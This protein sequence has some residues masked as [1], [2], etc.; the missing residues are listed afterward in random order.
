M[1]QSSTVIYEKENRPPRHREK[2]LPFFV[3]K[4]EKAMAHPQ[5]ILL[6]FTL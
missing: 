1:N 3:L 2:M 4:L 5:W 6:L